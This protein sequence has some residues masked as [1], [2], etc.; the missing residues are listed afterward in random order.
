[1][2]PERGCAEGP[3]QQ[4]P[5]TTGARPQST[6]AKIAPGARPE[7]SRV[8][9]ESAQAKKQGQDAASALGLVRKEALIS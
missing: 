5:I 3:P 7:S 9:G 2:A 8:A 4:H 1:M 6:S